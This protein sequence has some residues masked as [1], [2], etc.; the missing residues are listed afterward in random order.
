MAH[1]GESALPSASIATACISVSDLTLSNFWL[2]DSGATDH[3]TDQ[4]HVFL[5]FPSFEHPLIL[6]LLK[7]ALFQPL[8]KG[9]F[10]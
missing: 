9:M 2:I 5:P 7:D 10:L 3:M 6:A 8:E 1:Q 4:L